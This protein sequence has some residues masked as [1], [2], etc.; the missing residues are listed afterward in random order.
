LLRLMRFYA[1]RGLKILRGEGQYL[2]DERGRRYLDCHT[3]H[4][5]IERG[6]ESLV[7]EINGIPQYKNVARVTGVDLSRIIVEKTVEQFRR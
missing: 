7:L 3:G 4:D 1:P 5:L 2:W 6:S